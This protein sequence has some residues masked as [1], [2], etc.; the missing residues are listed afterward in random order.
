VGVF[1]DDATM[2][3][4]GCA[5]RQRERVIGVLRI[6]VT[7]TVIAATAIAATANAATAAAV[8]DNAT[9]PCAGPAYRAFDF[10]IGDWAVFDPAGEPM[11][12]NRIAAAQA[13]CALVESWRSERGLTGLSVSFYDPTRSKWR[14][15]WISPGSHIELEGD[16]HGTHMVLEGEIRYLRDGTVRPFRGTWAPLPGGGVHQTL[17]EADERGE[18][19]SWFEGIYQRA[20]DLDKRE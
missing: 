20:R 17:E 11:G 8:E 19:T 10:W 6:A 7:A 3:P 14:Q 9:A 5:R 13:G 2:S 4:R 18:W 12:R 1:R 16:L 15:L